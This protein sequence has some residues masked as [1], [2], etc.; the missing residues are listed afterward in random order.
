MNFTV[1]LLEGNSTIKS[2]ILNALLTEVNN[3]IDKSIQSI[4]SG[5]INLLIDAMKQEPEYLSLKNGR[6]REE[7]GIPNAGAVDDIV[8][9]LAN[10]VN[11]TKNTLK[12]TSFGLSGGLT[13]TAIESSNFDGLLDDASAIVDDT[14]RGYSLPWLEWLLLNGNQTIIK[15]YDVKFGPSSS[16][17]T[18]NAIMVESNNSWRVPA[19]FAGTEK[20]NW[21]TRAIDRI[22]RPLSNLIQT[23]MEKNI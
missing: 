15:K 10:T 14:L 16:S 12:S 3:M 4:R 1:K 11:I 5:T 17:R 13:I 9:K 18:G 23:T 7:L 8:N 19:E 2:L 20:N 21:T 22:E 6:L